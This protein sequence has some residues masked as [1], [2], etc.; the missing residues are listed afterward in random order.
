MRCGAIGWGV[1]DQGVRRSHMEVREEASLHVEAV[2]R[3]WPE[4]HRS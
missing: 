1:S 2:T 3:S 4:G